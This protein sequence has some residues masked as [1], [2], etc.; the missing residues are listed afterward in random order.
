MLSTC[1]AHT[2]GWVRVHRK[3]GLL[4]MPSGVHSDVSPLLAA[5]FGTEMEQGHVLQLFT[6]ERVPI[7]NNMTVSEGEERSFTFEVRTT[8]LH[9]SPHPHILHLSHVLNFVATPAS[10][11]YPSPRCPP[12]E[13]GKWGTDSL[14]ACT[15]VLGLQFTLPPVIPPSFSGKAFSVAYAVV[16]EAQLQGVGNIIPP[17]R[18]CHVPVHVRSK[19]PPAHLHRLH[20]Y[21]GTGGI[22]HDFRATSN[23]V[24]GGER[25]VC[26]EPRGLSGEDMGSERGGE[27]RFMIKMGEEHVMCLLLSQK[28]YTCGECVV[29]CID[30]AGAARQCTKVVLSLESHETLLMQSASVPPPS[31]QTM[32]HPKQIVPLLPESIFHVPDVGDALKLVSHA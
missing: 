5:K 30:F 21:G 14:H 13:S 1:S 16:V 7:M 8:P 24:D 15:D 28:V 9:R 2:V 4:D 27:Q 20:T 26:A 25:I 31:T 3:Q 29:A 6:S 10:T 18:M 12:N 23:S 19:R 32:H 22:P 17:L 11:P